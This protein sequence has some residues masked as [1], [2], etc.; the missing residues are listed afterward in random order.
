[1]DNT[2]TDLGS[3][4]DSVLSDSSLTNE[5]VSDAPAGDEAATN[6][7]ETPAV[8]PV[9]TPAVEPEVAPEPEAT[10]T[11]APE[12]DPDR[13]WT[14]EEHEKTPLTND[15]KRR[16]VDKN[17]FDTLYRVYKQARDI[18]R[19][20]GKL[21]NAEEFQG[22]ARTALAVEE[23]AADVASGDPDRV[24]RFVDHWLGQSPDALPH[25]IDHAVS[26]LKA[27]NPEL[28]TQFQG[29]IAKDAVNRM[30]AHA[31]QL[32]AAGNPDH[33]KFLYAA[34]M[35]DWFLNQDYKDASELEKLQPADPRMER[36]ERLERE[37]AERRQREQEAAV[38]AFQS[39]TNTELMSARNTALDESLKTVGQYFADRPETFSHIKKSLSE[40]AV[41][42]MRSDNLFQSRFRT[43]I[44]RARRSGDEG[45]FKAVVD[46]YRERFSRAVR[47]HQQA[48]VREAT[49]RTTEQNK[50]THN[51]LSRQAAKKEPAGAAATAAPVKDEKF[52]EALKSGGFSAAIESL[53]A[54]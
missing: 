9:E 5:N 44:D 45:A 15:G 1:M 19:V 42:E 38:R 23:M 16:I 37:A 13:E 22:I 46:L 17:R 50:A 3:S 4:L 53:L 43:A 35:S 20:W 40:K 31:A 21:P 18:E 25:V 2:T 14:D 49:V 54:D 33:E 7:E 26:K 10:E 48:I 24:S 11:P 39:K 32:K 30:Y 29:V 27:G 36:L 52:R 51:A 6:T 28:Y 41:E 12:D 34:Q 8:E 47:N